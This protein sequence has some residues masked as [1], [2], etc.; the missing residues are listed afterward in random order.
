MDVNDVYS[1]IIIERLCNV[2]QYTWY[3]ILA[4]QSMRMLCDVVRLGGVI[5]E[6]QVQPDAMVTTAVSLYERE[7]AQKVLPRKEYHTPKQK[8]TNKRQ[9]P[10]SVK[11][12]EKVK[13]QNW[14]HH[15]NFSHTKAP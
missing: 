8:K 7:K 14:L 9:R 15:T 13:E 10:S 4:G 3:S 12:Q 2:A 5:V 6:H 11:N 1:S